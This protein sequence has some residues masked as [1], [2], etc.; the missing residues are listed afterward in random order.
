MDGFAILVNLIA[1]EWMY[2]N[3][4]YADICNAFVYL[5]FYKIYTISGIEKRI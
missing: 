1:Y 4:L 2:Y 3:N 5:M